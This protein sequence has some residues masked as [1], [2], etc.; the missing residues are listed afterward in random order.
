MYIEKDIFNSE[1]FQ[2]NMGNIVL[3]QEKE[4]KKSDFENLFKYDFQ[5]L[6]VKIPAQQKQIL[7]EVLKAGFMLM[8]TLTEYIFVV[9]RAQLPQIQH[10]CRLRNCR[11][12]DLKRLKD[13]ASSSFKRDRFHSDPYLNN[14]LCDLYYKKWIENSYNGFA[15][16]VIVAEYNGEPV[17]FTTGK[18]YLNEPYGHLVLSAVS[19]K[20]RGIGVYTSMIYEGIVWMLTEHPEIEGIVVGTQLD[21][22]AV[23]KAWIRL[24]FTVYRSSYVL[25]IYLDNK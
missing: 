2:M 10:K 1:I 7:N 5:H 9:K 12:E 22:L 6:T 16:K 21:N 20:Y 17:G 23:Q 18:T 13:I 8:D 3:D 24:G 25:H 14:E 15:E 4:Y 11:N 19:E